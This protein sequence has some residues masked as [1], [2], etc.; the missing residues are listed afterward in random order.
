MPLASPRSENREWR[1]ITA[2]V[3]HLAILSDTLNDVGILALQ[4]YCG[5][6]P[7]MSTIV[8]MTTSEVVSREFRRFRECLAVITVNRG[9]VL[10]KSGRR[11][12]DSG[13][14]VGQAA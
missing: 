5:L 8:S 14:V 13:M 9:S 6:A 1:F 11:G 2:D 3:F 12:V 7:S 10:D 4:I